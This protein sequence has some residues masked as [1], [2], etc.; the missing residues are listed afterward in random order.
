MTVSSICDSESS[1]TPS[2]ISDL[3]REPF[4]ASSF[5]CP[6]STPAAEP[7]HVVLAIFAPALRSL[8]DLDGA[9]EWRLEPQLELAE[10]NPF[11]HLG[12][13]RLHALRHR[14]LLVLHEPL[15]IAGDLWPQSREEGV[16][17]ILK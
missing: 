1:F 15:H 17:P 2:R 13:G 5:V 4:L 11:Q 12:H 9:K 3:N 6:L 16:E 8:R 14:A 10:I 7:L